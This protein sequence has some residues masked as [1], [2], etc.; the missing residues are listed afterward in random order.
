MW[1]TKVYLFYIDD[2]CLIG[3][4]SHADSRSASHADSSSA[5]VVTS[6]HTSVEFTFLLSKIV[7]EL[8]R[9][10]EENLAIIK[11]VCSVLTMQDDPSVFL[12]SEEQLEAINI[13]NNLKEIINRKMRGCWRWDDLSS[14]RLLVQSV[15]SDC[16]GEM[17]YQFE[18][19]IDCHKKLKEIYDYCQDIPEGYHRIASIVS[20][21][22]FL[23]ITK[24]EFDQLKLFISQHYVVPPF[25]RLAAD[26]EQDI[27]Y[28]V[29][30]HIIMSYH[31][32]C[33]L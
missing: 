13:C 17:L 25:T 15:D 12:F 21:K 4:A 6:I 1:L 31:R 14:L 22:K 5:P 30:G 23:D 28:K 3:S 7:K 10:E 33:L 19:K 11:E 18:Q 9:N 32:Y 8:E 26:D 24:E 29:H 16:C 27:A 2:I 20:R